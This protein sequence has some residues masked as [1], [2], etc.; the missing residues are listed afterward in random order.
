MPWDDER[1][2]PI[3]RRDLRHFNDGPHKNR[4]SSRSRAAHMGSTQAIVST[5]RTKLPSRNMPT[6]ILEHQQRPSAVE[7]ASV[8]SAAIPSASARGRPVKG[9]SDSLRKGSTCQGSQRDHRRVAHCAHQAFLERLGPFSDP[10]ISASASDPKHAQIA[11]AFCRVALA[12]IHGPITTVIS[13][14]DGSRKTR[15]RS[16]RQSSFL[17]RRGVP[18]L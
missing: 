5:T 9:P 4:K 1:L 12:Q 18:V 17:F 16:W 7:S 14:K 2:N 11:A 8:S 6:R 13:P 10:C 15:L 3:G